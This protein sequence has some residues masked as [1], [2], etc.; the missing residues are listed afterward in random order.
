MKCNNQLSSLSNIDLKLQY[1]SVKRNLFFEVILDCKEINLKNNL[2]TNSVSH[3]FHSN[4]C[5]LHLFQL[6]HKEYFQ[7]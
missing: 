4:I 5:S 1:N 2:T 6:H 7:M 3:N